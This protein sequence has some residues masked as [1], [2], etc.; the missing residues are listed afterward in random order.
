VVAK[1]TERLVVSKKAAQNFDLERFNPRMLR[2]L[3]VRKEYQVNIS[4]RITALGNLKMT[5]RT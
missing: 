4:N 3:E 5:V 2:E 1:V